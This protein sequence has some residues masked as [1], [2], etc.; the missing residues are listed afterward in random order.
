MTKLESQIEEI[1]D[2]IL[3]R[4]LNRRDVLRRSL[5]LGLSAPIIA[6]LLAA[7]GGDDDDDDDDDEDD[8]GED[9]TATTGGGGGD[10]PTATEAAEGGDDEEDEPTATEAADSGD[11]EDEPTATEEV[12][13]DDK[14]G[15][16]RLTLL[17]WQAA[18]ILNPHLAQGGKDFTAASVFLLALA[19]F[20]ND[21]ELVTQL[22]TEIPSLENG[23]LA[24]DGTSVTWNLRQNVLWHD[25]T[26]FTAKD[27]V[28]TWEYVTHPDAAAVTTKSNFDAVE[29][30]EAVDDYTV[31]VTFT[32]STPAWFD[33]FTTTQSLIVPE[34]I[35]KDYMGA[36]ANDAPYNLDPIGTG[37]YIVT[38]FRPGDTVLYGINMD[39]FE[40]GK[41]HF[42]EVELKGGG[43]A[44]SAARAVLQTGDV[45]YSLNLQVEAE[46][47]IELSD[48]G[49][50]TLL[51]PEGPGLERLMIN[52]TD[53]NVDVDG[54]FSHISVPHPAL[55]ELEFRQAI[56]L[57][58][59]R[60]TI[61]TQ[62]YG[63]TGNAASNILTQPPRFASPNTS[64]EFNIDKA[65]TVL[66]DA[67]WEVQ[68]GVLSKDGYSCNF[69]YQTSTNSVRQKNQEIVKQALEEVGIRTEIKA[70]DAGVY[71]SSDPGNPDTYAHF[72][73][74]LEMFT[75]SGTV[76]PI[77]YMSFWKS[78]EPETDIPQKS[79]EWGGRN[80]ERWAGTPAAEEYNALWLEAN[81][82]IDPERQNEL[83]IGMNDIIV[84]EVVEI[85]L[86][87]RNSVNGVAN[88][89]IG[90][91]IS[92]WASSFWDIQNWDRA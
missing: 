90:H 72:Y 61:A 15:S 3:T 19:D 33:P 42:D 74:D 81:E 6:G 64:Y 48:G 43:D 17:N 47:L 56:A 66:A 59:D 49:V 57:L 79:N 87:A 52:F 7:C 70:I 36:T 14:G 58:C 86:V 77:R 11:D 46:I 10:D 39:Y 89:I 26:P 91:E 23:L 29:S 51:T 44:T 80:V 75:N 32:Q 45:D 53:P 62:L 41:P 67:G 84:N 55:S 16:G 65:K 37:P 5:A 38:D 54:E 4:G 50:G 8:G 18:T 27:V 34:H 2:A 28:F 21:G 63:P 30:V 24:E 85:P 13:A 76:Y 12:M 92:V 83:F 60:D 31:L 78:T 69:I 35:L 73:A 20:N 1:R 68:D 88:S 71:F 22:A 82:A 25:G 40:P 9:P